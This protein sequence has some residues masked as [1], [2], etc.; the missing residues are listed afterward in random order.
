MMISRQIDRYQE[1]G[2]SDSAG[3]SGK[4]EIHQMGHQ[5]RDPGNFSRS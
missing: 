3:P 2:L 4:S 1:N 5:E